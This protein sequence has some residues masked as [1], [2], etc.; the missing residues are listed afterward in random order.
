[1][2]Y[3]HIFGF[4]RESTEQ[5]RGTPKYNTF[6]NIERVLQNG[7]SDNSVGYVTSTT[8]APTVTLMPSDD[9]VKAGDFITFNAVVHAYGADLPTGGVS[10][11]IDGVPQYVELDSRAG[12]SVTTS[13][14]KKGKHKIIAEYSGDNNYT[15]ARSSKQVL[16][17]K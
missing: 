16:K 15:R 1:M 2:F 12:A 14:S 9:S 7:N 4:A 3:I 5:P 11:I 17:I 6:L 8:S 13:F 10:F